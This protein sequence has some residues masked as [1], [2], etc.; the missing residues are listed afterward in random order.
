MPHRADDSGEFVVVRLDEDGI[1]EVPERQRLTLLKR[2]LSSCLKIIG[3]FGRAEPAKQIEPAKV[4]APKPASFPLRREP[5]EA[6]D[7]MLTP[8]DIAQKLQV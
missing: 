3:S 5:R 4:E 1:G 8:E 7:E 6:V 2:L